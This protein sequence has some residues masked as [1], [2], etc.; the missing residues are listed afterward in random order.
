MP[1]AT[2]ILPG[3]GLWEGL[4]DRPPLHRAATYPRPTFPGRTHTTLSGGLPPA[5]GADTLVCPLRTFR[6]SSRFR[7]HL[8]LDDNRCDST[9]GLRALPCSI[10]VRA[11]PAIRPASAASASNSS[12]PLEP[13]FRWSATAAVSPKLVSTN[14]KSLM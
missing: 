10:R 12:N 4:R 11:S 14:S 1:A 6:P 8:Q 7:R 9:F 3:D 2:G 5:G 13:R